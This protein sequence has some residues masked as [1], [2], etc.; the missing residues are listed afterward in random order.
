MLRIVGGREIEL[1]E[2]RKENRKT[3]PKFKRADLAPSSLREMQFL[4][5]VRGGGG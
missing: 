5:L 2:E 4:A 1:R 3:S